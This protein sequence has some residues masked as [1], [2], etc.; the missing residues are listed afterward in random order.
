MKGNQFDR[1]IQLNE[2]K[3]IL[4]VQQQVKECQRNAFGK[5]CLAK[6]VSLTFFD[7]LLNIQNALCFIQLN[8]AIKLISF[9]T[10]VGVYEISVVGESTSSG[11]SKLGKN[12]SSSLYSL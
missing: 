8:D 11:S 4:D 6:G 10:V 5:A 3:C 1:I 9:H 7:L 2:A 12:T